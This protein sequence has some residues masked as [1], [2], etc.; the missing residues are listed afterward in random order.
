MAQVFLRQPDLSL[1]ADPTVR[2]RIPHLIAAPRTRTREMVLVRFEGDSA[3]TSF[4]GEGGARSYEL[5][6]RYPSNRHVEMKELLDLLELAQDAPDSRLALRTHHFDVPGL[7]PFEV[8][9]AGD[10][11]ET[12]ASGRAWDVRFTASTVAYSLSA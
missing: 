12:Y 11:S 5:T 8:V 6:C 1:F 3:P 10:I 2:V 4:R 9:V 7:G